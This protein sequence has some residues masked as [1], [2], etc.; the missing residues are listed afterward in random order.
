MKKYPR[1]NNKSEAVAAAPAAEHTAQTPIVREERVFSASLTVAVIAVILVINVLFYILATAFGLYFS[2]IKAKPQTLTGNTDAV[3][4]DAMAKKRT[5]KIYFCDDEESVST[6]DTGA[7]VLETAK[8]YKE[9][10]PG[11]IDIE[12]VNIITKR[13]SKGNRFPLSNY[14]KND[15]LIYKTSVIFECVESGE[16]KVVTDAYSSAGYADFYTIDS[17]GYT[18]S[19]DGEEFFATMIS[20]VL[21]A[22]HKKAYFTVTHS[23][24]VD[25]TFAKLLM[26]AGYGKSARECRTRGC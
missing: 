10:Y 7:L 26:A 8:L 22:E 5:V 25:Q 2:P 9:R 6:H 12:Y 3:F 11:F 17:Q 16:Y 4:A 21:A 15:E 18:L 14:T 1:I 24:Q 20:W 19:Y 23:E 13:D